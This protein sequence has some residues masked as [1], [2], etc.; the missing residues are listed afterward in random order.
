MKRRTEYNRLIFLLRLMRLLRIGEWQAVV[1]QAVLMGLAGACVAWCFLRGGDLIQWCY[2]GMD[3]TRVDCFSSLPW[4]WRLFLPAVGAIPAALVLWFAIRRADNPVPEYME[5][6]SLG[7][8]RLRRRQGV[9]RTISAMLSI[10]SGACIGRMGALLQISAV[11]ASSTGRLL[12]VSAPR[13]RLMVGCGAA[14]GM[15]V[16]YH[17][18]LAACLFVSE[19]LV[20]TFSIGSLAPLLVASCTAY[21]LVSLLGQG[22]ALFPH[23]GHFGSLAEIGTCVLLALVAAVVA[24][25]WVWILSALRKLLSG[26]TCW[27]VPRMVAAGLLVGVVSI[28]LPEVVGNGQEAISGVMQG[29]FGLERA[30]ILLGVKI[31]LIAIVFG[32]GTQGGVLTPTLMVGFFVGGLFGGILQSLGFSGESTIAYAF[33]GMAAFFSVAG[34]APVTALILAVELTMNASFIFPLMVGVAVAYAFSHILPGRSLYDSSTKP[35][36]PTAFDSPLSAMRV[37]DIMRCSPV[38]VHADASVEPVLRAMLR[39]PGENVP[40]ED[41]E[42]RY[43]GLILHSKME[44][45]STPAESAAALMAPD[46]P[47]LSPGMSLPVALELFSHAAP[48]SLPVVAPEDGHLLGLVSRSEL[49]RVTA[50]MLRKEMARQRGY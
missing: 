13:L 15:T 48:D 24:R 42:G 43:V 40:V 7:D 46:V 35:T 5:A 45:T 28:W 20:G 38:R 19:I 6:F 14:A 2:T 18:P 22:W 10:G 11:A 50:L 37:T 16:A 26:K 1:L 30:A 41:A 36:D 31:L 4:Q 21:G 32:V 44:T 27:L 49:Y 25:F 33:V 9:L 8:G 34:R 17:T 3:T 12:H 47:T 29:G 39:H 23:T